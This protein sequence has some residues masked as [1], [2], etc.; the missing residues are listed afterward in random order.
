[1]NEREKTGG[2]AFPES[3]LSGLP[4]GEFIQGR[5]GMTLRDYFAAMAMQALIQRGPQG[6]AELDS[7]YH[8]GNISNDAF[9]YADSM[10]AARKL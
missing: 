8:P 10:I 9:V 2:P 3:G 5:E 1:M 7:F 4:N 6:Y